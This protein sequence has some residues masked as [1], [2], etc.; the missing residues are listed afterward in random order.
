ME[1][2][3]VKWVLE[4]LG[5]LLA[6][7]RFGPAYISFILIW[8]SVVRFQGR[9]FGTDTTTIYNYHCIPSNPH[10]LA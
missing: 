1:L 8:V 2:D 3:G 9:P 4:V 7:G 5:L 6:S 10:D